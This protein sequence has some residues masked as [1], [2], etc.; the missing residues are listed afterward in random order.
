M[1]GNPVNSFR[2]LLAICF[3]AAV[4]MV[5]AA[6]AANAQ[7]IILENDEVRL[8]VS[9]GE[10]TARL[11]N[12]GDLFLGGSNWTGEI[13]LFNWQDIQSFAASASNGSLTLG[14][15]TIDGDL[16]CERHRRFNIDNSGWSFR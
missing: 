5:F 12:G 6:G 15:G 11:Y 9:P 14:G 3:V 2:S 16:F 8:E 1:Q 13:Y 7:I 10:Q 4:A